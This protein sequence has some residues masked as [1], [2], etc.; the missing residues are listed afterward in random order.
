MDGIGYI[1]HILKQEGVE[2]IACFPSNPLIE[3]VSKVGI[4]PIAFRQ[5]R[6][7]VMAADG[8][9][10]TNN[11]KKF[12]VVA[13]Q[14][15]AGAENAMGGLAQAFADNIP[16]LVLPGG[17]PLKQMGVRPNFSVV[18][19][20][21]GLVKHVEAIYKLEEVGNVMRRAFHA[22]RNGPPGPVVV[23][24]TSDVCSQELP[25]GVQN[26]HSPRLTLQMPANGDVKNAVKFLLGAEKPLIWAGR[27]VLFSGGTKELKELAELTSIPVFC[28]MPGKSAFDERHPLSL[29][30]G[31]G[32]TTLPAHQWIKD[33]ESLHS[34]T[35][36]Q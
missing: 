30:A 26:Y 24:M 33:C 6:G 25:N 21:R 2:W 29:G 15:Q 4:R 8:F 13:I 28:T 14:S 7:A 19:N 27:G 1:A 10:R 32:A 17:I 5:E 3:E 34:R 31:S 23:E 22:L 18:Q 36:V 9:S 35:F 20:Y 16:I 11:R 12:G